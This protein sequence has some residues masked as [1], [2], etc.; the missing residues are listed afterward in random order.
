[1]NVLT[2][3]TADLIDAVPTVE[4][5]IHV[6]KSLA[7][8][9][10]PIRARMVA[11]RYELREW[12]GG[13]GMA[14]VFRAWD[15]QLERD[16]AI[17]ILRHELLDDAHNVDRF[18][19]E[20]H[21][22]A[23]VVSD[24]VVEVYDSHIGH[25][26]CYLVLRHVAGRNLADVVRS[27]GALPTDTALHVVLDVLAG[28]RE[29]HARDIVHRD[30]KP[31]NVILGDDGRAVLL[32]LGVAQA[33]RRPNLTPEM[34]T[35]GTPGFMPP[36]LQRTGHVDARSDLYQ[37]ALLLLHMTTSVDP[38]KLPA[39]A[40]DGDI[41]LRVPN[42]VASVIARGVATADARFQNVDHMAD[43]VRAAVHTEDTIELA[44]SDIEDI[45]DL[46][47]PCAV[48]Q[49]SNRRRR[50]ALGVILSIAVAAAA[51]G[52]WSEQA[53]LFNPRENVSTV[54]VLTASAAIDAPEPSVRDGSIIAFREVTPPHP[55]RPTVSTSPHVVTRPSVPAPIAPWFPAELGRTSPLLQAALAD[56]QHGANEE[57]I[58]RF[59][60]YLRAQPTG[61]ASVAVRVHLAIMER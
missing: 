3:Q 50:T 18:R 47:E 26:E 56:E 51:F 23:G 13:G 12:L 17:K 25:D 20:A 39:D 6:I 52:V 37:V 61:T 9:S 57:A 46:P 41:L 22:L 14:D 60:A 53:W 24:H 27:G 1:M 43:A 5:P 4:M 10:G 19:R 34:H 54:P 35:V 7:R 11:G 59:R 45:V 48:P 42:R 30:I 15:H 36:E 49:H 38:S 33:R 16:V 31:A 2:I 21:L 58:A 55:A 28:L 8:G 40:L 44:L 29:L 32:D